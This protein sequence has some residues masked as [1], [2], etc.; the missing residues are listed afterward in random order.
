MNNRLH[1]FT[2]LPI[3]TGLACSLV[4]SFPGLADSKRSD[5]VV[6]PN[7]LFHDDFSDTDSGWD[8]FGDSD[9]LTDYTDNAYH[10]EIYLSEFTFWAN[11]GIGDILPGD[12]RVEVDGTKVGGPDANDYGIICRYTESNAG[13]NFYQFVIT[14]DGYAGIILVFESSQNVISTGGLLEPYDEIGQGV[15]TNHIRAEC[16]GD[17]LT[18]SV[19][20][21]VL[22]SVVDSTLQSGDVGLIAGSYEESGV[23][24]RFDNFL[25]TRP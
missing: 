22:T 6:D 3:I 19:N 17:T 11:P 25:V 15:Q 18:L 4:S 9:G 16:I 8:R 10:I 12:V 1:L 7:I 13:A 23:R 20:G 21:S 2:L 14:S 24:I 5:P